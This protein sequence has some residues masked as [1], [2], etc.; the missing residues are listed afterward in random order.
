MLQ[1]S[2]QQLALRA[3]R[4]WMATPEARAAY[5]QRKQLPEPTFGI[6]KEQQDARRFLLRG[7]DN[8]QAEWNLLVTAFN[9]RTLCRLWQSWLVQRPTE[10]WRLTGAG[11]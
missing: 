4:I 1:V 7:I 2:P 5:R 8:V 11:G 10:S 3:H 6:L 9:L